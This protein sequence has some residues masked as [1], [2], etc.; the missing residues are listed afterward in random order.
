MEEKDKRIQELFDRIEKLSRQQKVFHDE[1]YR[2]YGEVQK[3]KASTA[4]EI[5]SSL[6]ETPTPL[7][8]PQ[9]TPQTVV[10]EKIAHFEGRQTS[11][12]QQGPAPQVS[13]QSKGAWEDFVG[14]NL[15]N[16]VGIAVLV[17]GVAFGTKYSIDNDLIDP[18]TRIVLG[19]LSGVVLTGI[20]LRLRESHPGFSAVLLSG[21]MAV[22]Y[23]ITYAAHSFYDLIPQIPAF[24]LM[25]MFT[26]FT[27]FASLRYNME[28]IS[29]IALVGAY[30]VPLLLSDGSGRVVVLFTYITIINTGILVLA[31]HRYWKRLYYL[32]FALTWLTFAS[33]F[34]FTFHKDHQTTVSLVFSSVFF[35]TFYVTFLAHK[36]LRKEAL[37]RG[38]VI[39]MLANSFVFYGFGYLTI[40][41]LPEGEQYLG[42]FTLLTAV[43]HFVACL[44]IYKSQA[45]ASD[46]FYFV[47][48]MVLVFL[49]IAVPVQLEGNWVTLVWA[50]EAT[51]MFWIGRTKGLAVYEKISYPL[52][53]LTFFSL[54]H[55]W[56]DQYP[57]S[58]YYLYEHNADYIIFFNIHFLTSM[59]VAAAFITIVFLH[60]RYPEGYLEKAKVRWPTVVAGALPVMALAIVYIGFYKEIEAYWLNVYAGSRLTI[61]GDDG[62]EYHRYNHHLLNLK[63]VWLLIFSAVFAG[64]FASMV[65]TRW[66]TR[67]AVLGS[68]TLNAVVL[69]VF[70]STGSPELS[71]LRRGY[72]D[73]DL[74]AYY[75][76]GFA[77]VAIRYA[78]IS[79]VLAVLWLSM[80][81]L[82]TEHPG[83]DLRKAGDL[84]LHF[85]ALALLSSEL[86]HWLD[87]ARMENSLK[88]SLSI[89]WGIYAL[90]MIVYGL[91]RDFKHIRIGGIVLFAATLLKL[92][93]YD[94]ADMSTILKT[95][96][97][98]IL[99]ALLLTAS[100]IYNKFKRSAGNEAP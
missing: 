11:V 94:M 77:F 60:M 41:L 43:V 44:L 87:M 34:S 27:V 80:R 84:Y 56:S 40:T 5:T 13:R 32:A 39:S 25:V 71:S 88:L 16:K 75:D 2:L 78:A 49:T 35:V 15:L 54:L 21:G 17:I 89:L 6:D 61:Q 70:V 97:M 23:F 47:A 51:L 62:V 3:L 30:A 74:A 26:V 4:T 68:L 24:V 58:Y 31:F 45:R 96:V 85:I 33:W 20:A 10:T 79:A 9:A 52:I 98:I 50:G 76:A 64:V 7:R 55:D 69:I 81:L 82:R 67:P 100:F 83:H 22:F 38:D 18:L 14:T 73:Q 1:I 53:G 42:L 65:R 19:Y 66:S 93:A 37:N 59:L 90:F 48:G 99:G 29:I 86:L 91:S 72:L 57:G 95:I 28:A 36:L 63:N 46:I 92:F 8:E 12:H